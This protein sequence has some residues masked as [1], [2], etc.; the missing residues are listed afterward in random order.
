MAQPL[1]HPDVGRDLAPAAQLRSIAMQLQAMI[2]GGDFGLC[3]TDVRN[4]MAELPSKL[5]AIS[6]AL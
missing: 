2:E 4:A 6:D 1:E 3:F 5:L